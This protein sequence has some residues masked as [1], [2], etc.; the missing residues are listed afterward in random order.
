MRTA[1]LVIAFGLLVGPL[2]LGGNDG[3]KAEYQ[4]R[5][6]KLE[7][8][9]AAGHYVLGLWCEKG[10]LGDEARLEFEKVIALDPDHAGARQG[11]GYVRLKDRW[12]SRDQAMK[13]K[14]LIRHEG[15]WMLREEV[16]A[17][18]LPASEKKRKAAGQAKV[19]RLLKKMNQGGAKV[20]RIAVK[21]MEGIP[22][23][24][25]VEPL[26]YALRYPAENVRIFAAKELGRIA[27]RRSLP[28]LIHRSVIDPSSTVREVALD[29]AMQFGDP[30]LLSPYVK[31]LNSKY[32]PVRIHAATAVGG[33]GDV[34]GI[35]YLVYRMQA[36]G[37]GV[38]RSHIYLANQLSFI[39]D[40]DVE[41]AQ[42]AFIADP[43]V[44]ILQEGQVLDV[45]VI[46]TERRADIIERRVIRNSLKKLSGVDQGDDP[47][48]WAKWW[49]K[50][51]ERLLAQASVR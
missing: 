10:G 32:Q 11:L 29:A 21:A 5:A 47:E 9:D 3:T 8:N 33:L 13:A 7:A 6:A 24:H 50:N 17:Q 15:A 30:N 28:P 41:V 4:E 43:M 22:D 20:E 49:A 19:R 27:D 40:F 18:L 39:Q 37:G 23:G 48:Q 34:R 12:L 38:S 14:G 36:H 25:K 42:T 31:A 1:L 26:A 35:Q 45:R 46:A 16:L 44:G 2:A 51:R